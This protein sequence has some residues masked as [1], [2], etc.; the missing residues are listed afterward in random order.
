[1]GE[2]TDMPIVAVFLD[3]SDEQYGL[4][5]KDTALFRESENGFVEKS[6]GYRS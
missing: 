6:E 5:S 3:L 4:V 2:D 1:M